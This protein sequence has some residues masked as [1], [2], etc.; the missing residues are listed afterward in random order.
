M[1]VKTLHMDNY[2]MSQ[3]STVSPVP[4]LWDHEI[5]LQSLAGE[6]ASRLVPRPDQLSLQW[7]Q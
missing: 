3:V 7:V 2:T 6:K 4:R 5:M 1:K